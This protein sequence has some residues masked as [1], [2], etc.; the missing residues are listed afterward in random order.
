[1]SN[2]YPYDMMDNEENFKIFASKEQVNR[3]HLCSG[4]VVNGVFVS[5]DTLLTNATISDCYAMIQLIEK[6]Y[7]IKSH[8]GSI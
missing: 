6:G 1:M 3:F 5:S 7:L 8:Y 4:E 2:E